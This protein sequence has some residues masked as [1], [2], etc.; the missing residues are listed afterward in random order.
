[1]SSSCKVASAMTG[2]GRVGVA[3]PE[4]NQQRDRLPIP[5]KYQEYNLPKMAKVVAFGKNRKARRPE[6]RGM[7]SML[8]CHFDLESAPTLITQ[9]CVIRV[10]ASYRSQF[11]YAVNMLYVLVRTKVKIAPSH[12][13]H[14]AR[15]CR[16]PPA[17]ILG[18]SYKALGP[19]LKARYSRY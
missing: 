1:M 7:R 17:E 2:I 11:W 8:S 16:S 5:K 18:R 14:S 4:Q 10:S 3:Q 19:S 13:P 6:T 9:Y 12:V 15:L